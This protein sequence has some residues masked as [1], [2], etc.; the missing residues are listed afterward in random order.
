MRLQ[1]PFIQLPLRFDAT[2]MVAEVAALGDTPWRPHPNALPGN[3]MLPLVAVNG[4]PADES[5]AGPMRPTPQLLRCPLLT[6]AIASL[7]ATVGR[8]RLMRL[9]GQAEVNAHVDQ[10]Y[11]W[12][13]RVRVHVPI[14][15]QP[16]VRFECGGAATHMAAG[17][18]WIFDTWRLHRVLNDSTASRIHLVIDTVGSGDFWKLVTQ[19]KPHHVA[20]DG[21]WNPQMQQFEPGRVADFACESVNVPA[22]MSPWEINTHLGQLFADALEHPALPALR[23]HAQR[24]LREWRGL[25]ARYGEQAEGR[26]HYR[27]ALDQFM[28]DVRAPG[29]AVALRNDVTWFSAMTTLVGVVAVRGDQP[30]PVREYAVS[31]RA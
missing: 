10:G 20:A 29:E 23:L 13:E 7:S 18:C 12:S 17:E 28:Q 4:D 15:T 11:Y 1:F 19:G 2:A 8:T 14:V 30:L 25:W 24:F 27:R 31:D 9:A 22:V 16:T 26:E 5:F 21:R 6:Q 3:S